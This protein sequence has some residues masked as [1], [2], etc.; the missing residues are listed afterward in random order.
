MRG[1]GARVNNV[2]FRL[3]GTPCFHRGDVSLRLLFAGGDEGLKYDVVKA[4][5]SILEER[6]DGKGPEG[7]RKQTVI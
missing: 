5:R 4:I 3:E 2:P 6:S 1:S 7:H